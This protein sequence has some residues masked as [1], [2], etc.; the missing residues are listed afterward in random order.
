MKENS[1]KGYLL[2]S[3]A[4][5]AKLCIPNSVGSG[6]TSGPLNFETTGSTTTISV[7]YVT[8][9]GNVSITTYKKEIAWQKQLNWG[10][11]ISNSSLPKPTP[12]I[13]KLEYEK[14]L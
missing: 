7:G 6:S 12:I 9:L 8:N 2:S 4:D 10:L 13:N 14:R 1:T 3:T 5:T 11:L